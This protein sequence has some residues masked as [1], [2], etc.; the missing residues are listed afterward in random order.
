MRARYSAFV[1]G[2]EAFLRVS[3]D[4]A[5][6]P[7]DTTT[8]PAITWTRLE[9]LEVAA[10]DAADVEGQVEFIAHYVFEDRPGTLHERSHFRRGDDGWCYVG[11]ARRRR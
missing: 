2:D 10:G 9:I 4:P 11:P 1:R 8:D 5:T 7:A 6:R 3:W